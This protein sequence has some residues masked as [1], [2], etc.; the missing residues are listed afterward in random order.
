MFM[1]ACSALLLA[2]AAACAPI[3]THGPR[4]E[5]GFTAYVTM[6]A[7]KSLCSPE[8]CETILVPQ[9][10]AGVRYGWAATDSTLGFSAGFTYSAPVVSSELDLYVQAPGSPLGLDAGA[11]VLAAG[12]HAMPYVQ[13]GRM[14]PNGSGWYTTQGYAFLARRQIDIVLADNYEQVEPRYWAPTVAYR[15][16]GH[17]GLHFYV[18]GA[19]GTA[20]KYD[21]NQPDVRTGRQPVRTVMTG[22]VF[23]VGRARP[24]R[25]GP[26]TPRPIRA[27][28]A[29]PAAG[30]PR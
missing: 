20:G 9:L 6:G 14:R 23:D 7:G 17:Y 28:P 22:V 26:P 13:L 30:Q 8:T 2:S 3:V 25:L 21:P 19:F 4:V 5:Q 18:T 16:G 1:K 24:R 10:G 12:T 27:V 15:T 11:G 29:P